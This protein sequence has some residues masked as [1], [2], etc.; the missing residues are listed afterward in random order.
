MATD[1]DA[2]CDVSDGVI[3]E[4]MSFED[5]VRSAPTSLA[6]ALADREGEP[7]GSRPIDDA[8]R[9]SLR[10]YW[11]SMH[12]VKF[13]VCAGSLA[14]VEQLVNRRRE[15]ARG[16]SATLSESLRMTVAAVPMTRLGIAE[17]EE[18]A[19]DIARAA[20]ARLEDAE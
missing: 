18:C 7:L 19:R 17:A 6:L 13:V 2:E 11:I 16:S 5:V 1:R 3:I 12:E 14:E 9:P 15:L 10:P 8:D 4:P 20:R